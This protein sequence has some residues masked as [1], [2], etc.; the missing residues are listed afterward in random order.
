MRNEVL[1]RRVKALRLAEVQ[2]AGGF[3]QQAAE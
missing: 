2:A 1:R 3:A